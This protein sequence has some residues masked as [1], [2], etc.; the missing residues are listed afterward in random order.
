MTKSRQQSLKDGE[1]ASGKENDSH[2]DPYKDAGVEPTPMVS[3]SLFGRQGKQGIN[4]NKTIAAVKQSGYGQKKG[5]GSV[6]PGKV[7]AT[8]DLNLG[9]SN[10]FAEEK[11]SS[12]KTKTHTSRGLSLPD[13]SNDND[14]RLQLRAFIEELKAELREKEQTVGALQRNFESLSGLCLKAETE[15]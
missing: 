2:K 7:A 15:K 14:S 4:L 11:A 5:G 13:I 6:P 9:H 10:S 12:K 1:G 8:H 3:P